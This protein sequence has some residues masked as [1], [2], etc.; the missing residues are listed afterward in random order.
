VQ[1][2]LVDL[3]VRGVPALSYFG[4]VVWAETLPEMAAGASLIM[5]PC[6]IAGSDIES[7]GPGQAMRCVSIWHTQQT[8]VAAC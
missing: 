2:P 5:P 1:A 7:D 4:R 6:C 3:E 8:G